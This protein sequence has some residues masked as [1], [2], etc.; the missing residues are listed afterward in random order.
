L[1]QEHD[2]VEIY[3]PLLADPKSARLKRAE[4]AKHRAGG[5]KKL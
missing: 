3:R 5:R 2:R 1:V 4:R